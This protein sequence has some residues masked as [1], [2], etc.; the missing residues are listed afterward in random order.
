MTEVNKTI[1]DVETSTLQS[2][3]DSATVDP[4]LEKKILRELDFNVVPV[5]GF[6]MFVSF[7]DRSNIG[8]AKIQGMTKELHM[9][10]NDYNIA[11]MLFTIAY[12]ICGLPASLIFKKVEPKSLS[13][14]M[15]LWGQSRW[16]VC[17][18]QRR[19]LT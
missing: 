3:H 18:S 11:V 1:H 4:V 15:F 10:G 5:L 16:H 2:Q 7:V 12:I 6:F 13:A 9:V 8:N 14:M 19:I 17:V